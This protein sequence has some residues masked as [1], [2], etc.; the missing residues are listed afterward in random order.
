M[1]KALACSLFALGCVTTPTLPPIVLETEF[2]EVR[3]HSRFTAEAV[4][5][6]L[7]HA[8]E[9]AERLD[10]TRADQPT[11]WLLASAR[12]HPNGA[13]AACGTDRIQL[14]NDALLDLPGILVHELVH[15]YARESPYDG[16]PHFIEEGLAEYLAL[17]LTRVA[18][19]HDAESSLSG[20]FSVSIR[21]FSMTG[22]EARS[23]PP[24]KIVSLRD[25]GCLVVS[26][27]GLERVRELHAEGAEPAVYLAEFARVVSAPASR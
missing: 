2:G 1:R 6:V 4:G 23:L 24:E 17:E 25:V 26:G 8:P 15:W 5:H 14:G 21:E 3:A 20:S 12:A 22:R 27:L 19:G 13:F 9:L 10:S 16:L 7:E 18:N 11:V